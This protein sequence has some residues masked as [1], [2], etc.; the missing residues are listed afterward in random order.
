M[1]TQDQE[2]S[3]IDAGNVE[4]DTIRNLCY[5]NTIWW[6]LNRGWYPMCSS[7]YNDGSWEMNTDK[8]LILDF[9]QRK[10]ISELGEIETE[11]FQLKSFLI[12]KIERLNPS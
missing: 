2:A 5:T 8:F 10:P 7:M 4:D 6:Y 11:P 3:I 9:W 12:T 1:G